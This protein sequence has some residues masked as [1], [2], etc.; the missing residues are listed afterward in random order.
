MNDLISVIVATY[1]R[2]DALE[3]VLRSL[4]R[5]TE[6]NFEV[7]VAG[8]YVAASVAVGLLVLWLG[9]VAVAPRT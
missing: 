3:A 2:P 5:Q 7:L 6:S 9:F 8:G 1:N 4:S